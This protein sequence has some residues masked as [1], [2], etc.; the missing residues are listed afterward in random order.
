MTSTM[1]QLC[2]N[3]QDR[4]GHIIP[5]LDLPQNTHLK[6]AMIY[7]YYYHMFVDW[8]NFSVLAHVA[9]GGGLRGSSAVAWNTSILLGVSNS[10]NVN[11]KIS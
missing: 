7:Y 9:S 11:F 2:K 4:L 5:S 6:V 3:V 8:G 1:M 10:A